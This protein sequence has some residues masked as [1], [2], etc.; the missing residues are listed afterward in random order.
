MTS[1]ERNVQK[2]QSRL[3]L[4]DWLAA[5]GWFLVGAAAAWC[6][7]VLSDKLF[8][9]SLPLGLICGLLF[10]ASLL[11]SRLWAF[12]RR[13]DRITAAAVLDHAA[14]LKERTSS[15]LYCQDAAD[16]FARAVVEDAEE[17]SRK[18]DVRSFIKI[19]W[20]SSLSFATVGVLIGLI[21][22]WLP[23]A[24]LHASDQ[25]ISRADETFV[26]EDVARVKQRLQTL[27]ARAKKNPALDDLGEPLTTVAQLPIEKMNT[28]VEVRR[29]AIKNIDKLA[30]AIRKA[31]NE[32]FDKVAELKKMFRGLKHTR[33]SKSPAERLTRSLAKGDFRAAQE[34]IKEM[35]EQLAKLAQKQDPEQRE[36]MRKRI[37]NLAKQLN[38]LAEQKERKDQLEQEL[39]KAGVDPET[40]KRLLEN[41]TKADLQKAKE[42]MKKQGVDPQQIKEMVK[43]LQGQQKAGQQGSQLADAMQQAAQAMQAD[44]SMAAAGQQLMLA[45]DMLNS[46]EQLDQQ[47]GE[48]D[49]MMSEAQDAQNELSDQQGGF[50]Q[51]CGGGGCQSCNGTGQQPGGGMGRNPGRGTGGR[52]AEEK[53]GER[54]VRRRSPIITTKGGIIGKMFIDGE[55]IRGDVGSQAVELFS[56]AERDATDALEQNRIPNQYRGAVKDY[57]SE[58]I[59]ELER[60]KPSQEGAQSGTGGS[61]KSE[62]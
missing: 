2:T 35:R 21:V 19:S 52:A 45:G 43:K 14:G 7:A 60:S 56:A 23:I 39:Q 58:M 32:K 59:R 5:W 40:A 51:S 17:A 24:P 53:T 36:E 55:Q 1:V 8:D 41:L 10:L 25:E 30:D 18:I 20:P 47:L 57:F 27:Q 9:L 13:R 3:G 11:S 31:R 34:A 29:E 46:M 49:S 12:M 61:V 28:P 16:P 38:Q 6:L 54:W 33:Q 4:N 26:Q 42:Q 15:S 62:E 48:L 44:A 50:C 22:T 37:A